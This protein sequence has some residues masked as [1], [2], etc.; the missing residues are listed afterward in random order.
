VSICLVIDANE[1][2]LMLA[3]VSVFPLLDDI[4]VQLRPLQAATT[5]I[6]THTIMNVYINYMLGILH[7]YKRLGS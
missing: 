3:L 1:D 5:T 6:Y 2:D 4:Q 7:V